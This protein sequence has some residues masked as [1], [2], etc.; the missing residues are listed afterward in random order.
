MKNQIQRIILGGAL[1]IFL[2]G[3]QNEIT[4]I[5]ANTNNECNH[6]ASL[7]VE[8]DNR[9]IYTYCLND[10]TIKLNDKEI[11]LK[12]YIEENNDAI[13]RIVDTLE[14]DGT[15]MD[16]GT[17]IY[18][19]ENLTVVKC[20]KLDGNRDVYIGNQNMKFKE[21]FCDNNNYTFVRTY[22]IKSIKEYTD[23]Q[24]TED[25]TP[26]GYGNSFE[27]ELQQFQQE[28]K[29]AIINNLW[30]IKLEPN[31]TYEFEFQLYED[32]KDVKDTINYIFKNT[33]IVEIRETDKVGLEQTQE[34][35]MEK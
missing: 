22:T 4:G 19:G 7:L 8:K 30:E 14:L 6:K 1:V 11:N 21:N 12:T 15:L 3:C 2:T 24:Y 10:T 31:K 32:A 17:K 33:T 5:S 25:G 9:K 13:D 35:I 18:K 27:V 16:G 26:V 34:P 29:K 28:S 20:N 23:Q